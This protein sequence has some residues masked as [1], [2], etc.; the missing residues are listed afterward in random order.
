[1]RTTTWH[2]VP[3]GVIPSPYSSKL[4]LVIDHSAEPFSPKSMIPKSAASIQLDDLCRCIIN[5]CR[6]TGMFAW[7][8]INPMYNRL[9]GTYGSRPYGIFGKSS[10]LTH[11]SCFCCCLIARI[12][13]PACSPAS[14]TSS[15]QTITASSHIPRYTIEVQPIDSRGCH[16]P[17]HI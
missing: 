1:V 2:T 10:P 14:S 15:T 3:T 5:P 6:K 9:S 8:Y 17:P 11:L 4:R 13:H 16:F 12:C 7:L